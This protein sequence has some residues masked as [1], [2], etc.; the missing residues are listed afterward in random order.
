[1]TPRSASPA[2]S[3]PADAVFDQLV[4]ELI[5]QLQ[6]GAAPD[7]SALARE[8]PDYIALAQHGSNPGSS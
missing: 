5:A 1:M 4:D 2:L 6:A 8:H 3:C 7:W